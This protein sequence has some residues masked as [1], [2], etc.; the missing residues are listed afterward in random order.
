M[1]GHPYTGTFGGARQFHVPKAEVLSDF[2][3]AGGPSTAIFRVP[4]PD[5]RVRCKVTLLYDAVPKTTNAALPYDITG[6]NHTIWMCLEDISF[7]GRQASPVPIQNVVVNPATGL[8]VTRAAPLVIPSDA[9]VMG[10][11]REFVSAGDSLYGELVTSFVAASPG[12]WML[13]TRYQPDGQYLPPDEWQ[14]IVG[15][16]RPV[17]IAKVGAGNS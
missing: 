17:V 7:Q 11:S 15:L 13:Y 14:A 9:G 3:A 5:S 8:L 12:R 1:E 4:L 6:T 2:G 10:F 16:C